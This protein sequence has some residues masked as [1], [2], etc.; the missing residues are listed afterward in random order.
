MVNFSVRS[1]FTHQKFNAK[2]CPCQIL[3]Y[4]VAIDWK[5]SQLSNSDKRRIIWMIFN[6]NLYLCRQKLFL[7]CKTCLCH[8]TKLIASSINIS[9]QVVSWWKFSLHMEVEIKSRGRLPSPTSSILLI[10]FRKGQFSW[11]KDISW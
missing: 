6:F 8:V 3:R 9:C 4:R 7:V 1:E 2:Q 10:Y 5:L 11:Q